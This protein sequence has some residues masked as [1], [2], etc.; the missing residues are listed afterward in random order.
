MSSKKHRIK[1]LEFTIGDKYYSPTPTMLK[2]IFDA[3]HPETKILEVRSKRV[4]DRDYV[5]F[6]LTNPGYEEIAENALVPCIHVVFNNFGIDSEV[7][8]V[9]EFSKKELENMPAE[10]KAS[11]AKKCECGVG[12]TGGKHSY[13]CDLFEGDE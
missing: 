2:D 3:L 9:E 10:V 1:S 7:Q 8:S 13:Y 5:T 4:V 11:A 12:H 6:I